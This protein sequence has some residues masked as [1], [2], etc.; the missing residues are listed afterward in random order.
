M[1][2]WTQQTTR[3]PGA[4]RR[5]RA[6][7]GRECEP[8]TIPGYLSFYPQKYYL[9]GE[10]RLDRFL[11]LLVCP[12]PRALELATHTRS[13]PQV[14][15]VVQKV[16]ECWVGRR[17]K[18]GVEDSDEVKFSYI[19]CSGISSEKDV[20]MHRI[21]AV[22]KCRM[23]LFRPFC[24]SRSSDRYTSM[25]KLQRGNPMQSLV[26]DIARDELYPIQSC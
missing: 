1:R 24:Q 17:S 14:R 16:F 3:A 18:K 9:H 23:S 4:R 6:R 12:F 21:I 15:Q 10:G 26:A 2:R 13:F 8:R 25:H 5:K 22:W 11:P 20:F 7:K 19:H